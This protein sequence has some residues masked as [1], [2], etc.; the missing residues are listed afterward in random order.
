MPMQHLQEGLDPTS[1]T[2]ISTADLLQLIRNAKPFPNQGFIIAD[3]DAPD[4]VASP[5]LAFFLWIKTDVSFVPLTPLELYYY[6]GTSWTLVPIQVLDGS[7]TLSKFSL[8]GTSPYYIIQVAANG[9]SLQWISIPNA[10]Q[11][12]TIPP[13]KILAPADLLNYV[14][15]ARSGLSSYRT[16]V[17]FFADIAD[18]T[19]PLNKLVFGGA[20]LFLRMNPT[21]NGLIYTTT[22]IADILAAGGTAGQF[23]KRN[24]GNTGWTFAASGQSFIA[25]VLVKSWSALDTWTTYNITANIPVGDRTSVRAVI[26][27]LD[28]LISVSGSPTQDGITLVQSRANNA[29]PVYDLARARGVNPAGV[30]PCIGQFVVPV[31]NTAGVVTVD[32]ELIE[33]QASGGTETYV[34]S[35]KMIGYL[36]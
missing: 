32:L 13:A 15:M 31:L 11:D 8:V 20:N 16:I 25:P 35:A 14:L 36:T 3:P 6:N 21:A 2:C 4:V 29:S 34:A 33:S 18:N 9:L 28:N 26:L 23:L 30:A 24:A 22:D 1:L 27:Y 12:N 5:E 19:I 7:I 17:Q 10:I